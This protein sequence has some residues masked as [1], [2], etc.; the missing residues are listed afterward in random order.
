MRRQAWDNV[1]RGECNRIVVTGGTE[2]D[3]VHCKNLRKEKW[4]SEEE[5]EEGEETTGVRFDSDP[6]VVACAISC[7]RLR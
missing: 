5:E 2:F 7:R 1:T 6:F 3:V 4:K